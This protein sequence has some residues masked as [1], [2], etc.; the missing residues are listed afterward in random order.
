MSERTPEKWTLKSFSIVEVIENPHLTYNLQW[1]GRMDIRLSKEWGEIKPGLTDLPNII[2]FGEH[3]FQAY[4]WVICGYELVRELKK[5]DKRSDVKEVY[6]LFRRVRVPMVKFESPET[7]GELD[8]P[9]DFGI[10]RAA[11]GSENKELG[12]A[13]SA[14]VFI[15]REQLAQALY[16]LF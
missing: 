13:V 6:E 5:R 16:D 2:F 8:Y 15:S 7:K 14:S 9:E 11:V 1:L 12:W 10:A 4:L 3:A